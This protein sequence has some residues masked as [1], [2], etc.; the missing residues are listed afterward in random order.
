[1]ETLAK[2]LQHRPS[3]AIRRGELNEVILV[4]YNI[5]G[6]ALRD[7]GDTLR[8]TRHH[9]TWLRGDVPI[10]QFAESP[11]Q[12]MTFRAALAIILKR[13]AVVRQ[14]LQPLAEG[15]DEATSSPAAIAA[16][17]SAAQSSIE[18]R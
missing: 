3:A 16:G 14:H 10:G 11:I 15:D 12:T 5:L 13:D 1:V 18:R 7:H 17:A 6:W 4:V 8:F 2:H 9:A